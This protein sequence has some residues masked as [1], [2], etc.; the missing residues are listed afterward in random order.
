M[1][2]A[3]FS[4]LGYPLGHSMSPFIHDELFQLSKLEGSY[5]LTSAPPEQLAA[6]VGEL[7]KLDGFNVTIPYKQKI[8]PFL[9]HLAGKAEL[10]ESVNTVKIADGVYT[11]YNTDC[12]G[13]LNSLALYDIPLRGKVLVCGCGGVA[14]MA[15]FESALAGCTVTI[16]VRTPD[17]DT[18]ELPAAQALA[19]ET[20]EKIPGARV[21]CTTYDHAGTGYDLIVNGTPAGMY[22]HPGSMAPLEETVAGSK[23]VFD[24]VYN[25]EMTLL[26]QTAKE[27]G[28]KYAGGM[29][30]LVLQAAAA[31]TIWYGAEFKKQ[32][33]LAVIQ[34]TQAELEKK[35]Q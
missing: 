3:R 30:M 11:G 4:L 26:L 13:F 25:P 33:L 32:D 35:N 17:Q 6:A 27:H 19:K 16:A 34:R 12:D 5:T 28:C 2:P 14:R 21:T 7:K 22:P 24:C 31:Q 8:I 9:D 10:Y 29:A 23:A 15:V 18:A 20:A 1:N